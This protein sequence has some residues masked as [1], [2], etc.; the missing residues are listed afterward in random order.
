MKI[1]ITISL[2]FFSFYCK[3]NAIDSLKTVEDV[4]AFI[5]IK[6]TNK[7]IPIYSKLKADTLTTS[8]KTKFFKLDLNNDGLTDLVVNGDYLFAV[9]DEGKGNVSFHYIDGGTFMLRTYILAYV[10]TTKTQVKLIVHPYSKHGVSA[11][12][13]PFYDTLVYKYNGF[14]EFNR[15]PGKFGISKI[16]ISTTQCFGTCPVFDLS[17][18]HD[19]MAYYFAKQYNKKTGR[20]SSE[21]NMETVKRLFELINYINVRALKDHYNVNW[22]DDQTINLTITYEDGSEKNIIDYGEI[23]TFGL[24]TLYEAL[25]KIRGTQKWEGN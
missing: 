1:I 25:Y 3:G 20:F 24:K 2:I 22:T 11:S 16:A 4:E 5:R 23:G 19:G 21:V 8:S 18:D 15:H 7:D 17:V 6:V 13:I 9:I 14:V 12:E 10:D